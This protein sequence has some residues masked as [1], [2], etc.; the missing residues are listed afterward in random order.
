MTT[1]VVKASDAPKF[2]VL[3]PEFQEVVQENY[4]E[5]GMQFD[6]TKLPKYVY[7][8][9]GG[10]RWIVKTAGM[11]EERR[12]AFT[13]VVLSFRT[14]RSMYLGGYVAGSN[15]P[16]DCSSQEGAVGYPQKDEAGTVLNELPLADGAFLTFGGACAKCPLNQWESRRLVDPRYSGNG[17]ACREGRV[18]LGLEPERTRPVLINLPSTAL[19]AWDGLRGQLTDRSLG[20]SRA[21]LE[22]SLH[23]KNSETTPDLLIQIVGEVPY[24][25]SL[26]LKTSMPD[27]KRPS[28]LIEAPAQATAE[29]PLA[30]DDPNFPPF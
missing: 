1:D 26:L 24:E 6:L 14:Q 16:P 11:P 23:P 22:F 12:E 7:P 2:A 25:D 8:G 30:E 29:P 21:I 15:D 18:L 13:G 3:A 9:A 27:I 17:K 10:D 19:N 5:E 20:L 4:G 28:L